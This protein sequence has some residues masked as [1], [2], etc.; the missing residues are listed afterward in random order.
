MASQPVRIPFPLKGIT[1]NLGYES[2]DLQTTRDCVN[3]APDSAAEARVRG[4]SRTGLTKR[5]ATS[6]SG[7]PVFANRVSCG[8]DESV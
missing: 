2:G 5:Y 1:T 4:G 3:V 7:T 8:D 6:V